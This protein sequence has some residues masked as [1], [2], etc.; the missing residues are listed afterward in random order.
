MLTKTISLVC[1][2][3]GFA[4]TSYAQNNIEN[5]LSEIAKNNKTIIANQQYWEAKKL[6]YKTGLTPDNP[7][8]A[9]EYLLGSPAGAGNQQDFFIL[10]SLDFPTA[11]IKKKQV[12]AHQV[13]Q[14]EYQQTAHRQDVLLEAKQYCIELIYL[15]KNLF[16]IKKRLKSVEKL[17]GDYQKKLD[18]GEATILELNKA[19]LQLLSVEN[20]TRVVTS[21]INRYNQRLTELNGGI[22][23]DFNDTTYFLA[24][25]ILDFNLLEKNIEENDPVIK[26]ILQQKEID[27]KKLELSKAMA[28]PRIEG[29]YHSQ[30]ILG[31]KYQGVHIGMTIPLWESKNTVK[32]QKAHLIYNEL[33]VENH[34]NQHHSEIQQLYEKYQSLKI[35]LEEYGKLLTTLNSDKLLDKALKL[36]EIS[37]IQYFLETSYYY[38]FYDDYLLMEK[39]YYRIV[40]ELHKYE[41]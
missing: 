27:Q 14:D 37:T 26:S 17:Q 11:Y 25:E 29:G 28:L 7:T 36:G 40:A 24:P 15:N 4:T 20:D 13:I 12:T 3:I 16:V 41:L 39:E 10:Q 38:N 22:L 1:L 31:Q 9:Y 23:V 5:V 35:T 2:A 21:K 6:L 32:H 18:N 30:A 33:Q 19:K 8:V 34:K